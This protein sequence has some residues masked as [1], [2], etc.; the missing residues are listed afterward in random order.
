MHTW[1]EQRLKLLLLTITQL[2][3]TLHIIM[4][5]WLRIRWGTL[6][7]WTTEEWWCRC[8]SRLVTRPSFF[9]KNGTPNPW[10]LWW[11]LA[12]AS[13]FWLFC[14]KAWSFPGKHFIAEIT[15]PSITAMFKEQLTVL[16]RASPRP[17]WAPHRLWWEHLPPCPTTFKRCYISCSWHYPTSLCSSLWLTTCGSSFRSSWDAPPGISYLAGKKASRS[18]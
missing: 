4:E 6:K 8:T 12:S 10:V 15:W 14:T 17:H 18:T 13:S 3:L 2:W 11:V 9:S 16:S 5:L 1:W 7:Q